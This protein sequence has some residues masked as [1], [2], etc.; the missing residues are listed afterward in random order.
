MDWKAT[1][2]RSQQPRE[3]ERVL[4]LG[5]ASATADWSFKDNPGKAIP[6]LFFEE[7]HEKA[8]WDLRLLLQCYWLRQQKYI[9]HKPLLTGAGVKDL[10]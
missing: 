7:V 3:K 1:E 8:K 5:A 2:Q 6:A 10:P 4:C 9:I